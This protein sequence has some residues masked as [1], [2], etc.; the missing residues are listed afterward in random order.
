MQ[1]PAI[2]ATLREHY[3]VADPRLVFDFL[4]ENEQLVDLLNKAYTHLQSVF[5]PQPTVELQVVRDPDSQ[6]EKQLFGYIKTD[7]P[8][9]EALQKLEAFDEWFLGVIDQTD[10]RL[11]FNIK[12]G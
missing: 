4:A 11:N 12:F 7:L 1:T 8:P 10:G 2:D 6:S 5:G 9:T 3:T